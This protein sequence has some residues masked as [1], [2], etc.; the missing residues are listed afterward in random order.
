MSGR[1]DLPGLAGGKVHTVFLGDFNNT[2]E[3]VAKALHAHS[4]HL[5]LQ[6]T[7]P[8]P[9]PFR[10]VTS[11]ADACYATCLPVQWPLEKKYPPKC[12]RRIDLLLEFNHTETSPCEYQC[13]KVAPNQLLPGLGCVVDLLNCSGLAGEAQLPSLPAR[14]SPLWQASPEEV[15]QWASNLFAPWFGSDGYRRYIQKIC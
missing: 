12:A 3:E 6:E 13:K 5:Q 10:F 11:S 2:E 15:Q 14:P 1:W 9:R 7:S 4:K 8:N